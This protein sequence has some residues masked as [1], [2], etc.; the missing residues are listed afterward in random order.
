MIDPA[1]ANKMIVK[2]FFL[3]PVFCSVPIIIPSFNNI[4]LPIRLPFV[5]KKSIVIIY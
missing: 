3:I 5:R 2:K 1:N 4:T